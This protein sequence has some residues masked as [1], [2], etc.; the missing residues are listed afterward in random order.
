MIYES[1]SMK[2][3]EMYFCPKKNLR[4]RKFAWNKTIF[5]KVYSASQFLCLFFFVSHS[6]YLSVSVKWTDR[7]SAEL[8]L[9]SKETSLTVISYLNRWIELD[10]IF[11]SSNYSFPCAMATDSDLGCCILSFSTDKV[12]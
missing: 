9:E 5:W 1:I 7:M 4:R 10:F 11:I 8:H 6:S 2:I 12:Y 3:Y